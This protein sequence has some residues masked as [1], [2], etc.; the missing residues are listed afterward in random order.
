MESEKKQMEVSAKIVASERDSRKSK[1]ESL[2]KLFDIKVEQVSID[3]EKSK[4]TI[5][6]MKEERER[7]K[8]MSKEYSLKLQ[9]TIDR[10]EE[11]S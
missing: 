9:A 8:E 6:L 2:K 11:K 3:F 7:E 10:H 4:K 5:I 1:Y